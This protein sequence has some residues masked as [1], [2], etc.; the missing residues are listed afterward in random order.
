MSNVD[1]SKAP[2]GATHWQPEN[3]KL[4]GAWFKIREGSR[5]FKMQGQKNWLEYEG[6]LSDLGK[7]IERPSSWTGEGLPPV[8]TK[9]EMRLWPNGEWEICQPAYYLEQPID[10]SDQVVVY[11]NS[12]GGDVCYILDPPCAGSIEFRPIRTPEQIA[13]EERNGAQK[14]IKHIILTS[15]KIDPVTASSIA[16]VIADSQYRKVTP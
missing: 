11:Q 15:F 1:W 7:M 14:D 8:G 6:P 13:A 4:L 3:S 10:H 2:E 16:G 9:C 12:L 5:L